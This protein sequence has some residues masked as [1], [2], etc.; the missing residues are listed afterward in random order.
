MSD[1]RRT[2]EGYHDSGHY[3]DALDFARCIDC[4]GSGPRSCHPVGIPAA[5]GTHPRQCARCGD[6]YDMPCDCVD[7]WKDDTYRS[8]QDGTFDKR[9]AAQRPI[10]DIVAD[11]MKTQ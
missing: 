8:V 11:W 6:W 7:S 2:A 4:D 5:A 10:E 3:P 1:H 9:V